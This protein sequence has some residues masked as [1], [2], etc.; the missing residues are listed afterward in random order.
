V[1]LAL[2][3]VLSNFAIAQK[4]ISGLVTDGE[5][6]EPLV[7]ASIVVTGTTKGTLSDVDGKYTLTDVPASA[8]SLTFS[9]TGYANVTIPIGASNTIDAKLGAGALLNEVVVVGYGSVR[10]V[11]AT[12]AVSSINEK[13]FN[14]GTNTS[15][16]QLMQGRVA[17]VQITQ[18]SGAPGGGINVRIRGTSS[19][20][21]GN[22][23]LFV[24]DGV[25]LSG[26]ATSAGGED[27]GFGSSAPKNPL[28][29]LNTDDI[30]KIDIC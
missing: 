22:N 14:K 5:N 16:E 3:S 9:F 1:L 29:F 19:V 25:P 18:N 28:N 30:E 2:F 27:G 15:I 21:G 24:V 10:K 20:R 8:T 11:D 6:N 12:G 17:G 4:T 7:G 13:D 23:P 26:D